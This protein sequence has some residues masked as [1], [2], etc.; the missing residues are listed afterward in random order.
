[1]SAIRQ[2]GFDLRNQDLQLLLIATFVAVDLAVL[3]VLSAYLV[4]PAI[5]PALMV[6]G[7]FVVL[8]FLKPAWGLGA[9]LAASALEL[10]GLP[11]PSGLLTPAEAALAL[12]AVAYI[13][14]A[15]V[16]PET[17]ALPGWRDIPFL[18]LL[19]VVLIGVV[20]AVDPAPVVRVFIFWTLFYCLYLQAQSLS[21]RDMRVVVI[22]FA[23]GAGALG[24]IGAY[25]YF[26]SGS[27]EL[28]AGGEITTTRAVGAL[29]D[30]N[31]YAGLLAL[32]VLP[33]LALVLNGGRRDLWLGIPVALGVA[34]LIF[35]LSRGG[36]LAFGVGLL[37]LLA[38]RRARWIAVALVLIVGI[39]TAAN[40]N[41]LTRSE[42]FGV[43][44]ERLSTLTRAQ[45][46]T[47][48]QRPEIWSAARDVAIEHPF[49]GVGVNQFEHEAGQR[50]VYERGEPIENAHS[51]PLSLAAETGIVG[52]ALFM[53]FLVQLAGRARVALHNR[54]PLPYVLALGTLAA[55][56]AFVVQG[57]TVA[58]IRAHIVMG[59]FLVL[60][61]LLTGLADNARRA[62]EPVAAPEDGAAA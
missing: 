33:A 52:L 15:L 4:H 3:F 25:G 10:F 9:A 31:Y 11:L 6:A 44:R 20:I 29:A 12:V 35:S 1:M 26:Q 45:L 7:A 38:W 16:R 17:V 51:V 37:V 8:A 59:S 48:S 13:V 23:L 34:G 57:L 42:Q 36:I 58:Q 27:V 28:L 46:A 39:L 40:L 19:A 62:Q 5:L 50:G 53:A 47:T 60:A 14:R 2:Q 55:L 61:G 22:G 49:A 32:A 41:P 54:D 24:A 18:L 43:V 21:P 30:A 56:V